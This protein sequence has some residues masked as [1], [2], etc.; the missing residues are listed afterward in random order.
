MLSYPLFRTIRENAIE[1][2]EHEGRVQASV[3]VTDSRVE[4]LASRCMSPEQLAEAF[5]FGY[6]KKNERVR[7]RLR[8][9][10]SKRAVEELGGALSLDSRE[11]EGTRAQIVLPAAPP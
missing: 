3:E 9:A 7:L 11:G 10:T 8:L 2:I 1:S 4:V 5:N 6:T